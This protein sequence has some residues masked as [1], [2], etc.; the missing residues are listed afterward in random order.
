MNLSIISINLCSYN[1]VCF[2]YFADK[3]VPGADGVMKLLCSLIELFTK[4]IQ[5]VNELKR[6]QSYLNV[7]SDR[8]AV[9]VLQDDKTRWWSTFRMLKRLLHLRTALTVMSVNKWIFQMGT[10]LLKGNG[11]LLNRLLFALQQWQSF[12]VSWRQNSV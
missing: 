12:N 5:N 6:V 11:M 9:T 4:S 1:L 2:I 10:C 7:Y 8:R 3:H